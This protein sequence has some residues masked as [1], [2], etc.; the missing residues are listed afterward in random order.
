MSNIYNRMDVNSCIDKKGIHINSVYK[1]SRIFNSIPFEIILRSPTEVAGFS[2][3]SSR[4]FG[5]NRPLYISK[6]RA[7]SEISSRSIG[8][9]LFQSIRAS[10]M[11]ISSI[12]HPICPRTIYS[13]EK[14]VSK[15][16]RR[17]S[18][19][20]ESSGLSFPRVYKAG[21]DRAQ[22]K[23]PLRDCSAKCVALSSLR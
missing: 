4:T 15:T 16:L 3:E 23:F 12:N 6:A 9:N 19:R 13:C 2:G 7:D 22:L 14:I 11:R 18:K 10:S 1:W 20:P 21:I 8:E 17:S 5:K